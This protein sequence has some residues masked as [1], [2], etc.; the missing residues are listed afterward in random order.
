MHCN[1]DNTDRIN[2]GIIGALIAVSACLDFSKTF[3]F[4][5]GMVLVVQA[6]IGWCSIPVLLSPFTPK[7]SQDHK[8]SPKKKR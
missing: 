2:R 3:Y 1:I 8:P 4:I 6:A 7:K 5:L